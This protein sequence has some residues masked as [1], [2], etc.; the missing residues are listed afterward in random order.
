MEILSVVEAKKH[1]SEILRRAG[2]GERFTVTNH[3]RPIA[4]ILPPAGSTP[5]E[6]QAA[7]ERIKGRRNGQ[8]LGGLSIREMIDEGRP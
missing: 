1:F 6:R 7:V 2:A 5:E 3:G 4:R 8:A